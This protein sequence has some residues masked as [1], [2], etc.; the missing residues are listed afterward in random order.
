MDSRGCVENSTVHLGM[1]EAMIPIHIMSLSK[2][3]STSNNFVFSDTQP[4]YYDMKILWYL[5][6]VRILQN[7]L[8]Y[9]THTSATPPNL[10]SNLIAIR[11]HIYFGDNG[12]CE[13]NY[14]VSSYFLQRGT[15]EYV[16]F[17][18]ASKRHKTHTILEEAQ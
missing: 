7:S 13:K 9:T 2:E 14:H 10:P 6:T 1:W 12:L 16:T 8:I 3:L 18:V 5:H 17:P 11:C 4:K 15:L